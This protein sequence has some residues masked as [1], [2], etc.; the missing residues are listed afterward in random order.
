MRLVLT[1]L[2]V[3]SLS[4]CSDGS[5]KAPSDASITEPTE[6]QKEEALV[7]WIEASTTTYA[8]SEP[9]SPFE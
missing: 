8:E 2:Y 4:A 7:L 6:D 1:V 3:L 5:S 9:I